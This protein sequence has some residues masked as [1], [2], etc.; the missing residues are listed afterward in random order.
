MTNKFAAAMRRATSVTRGLNVLGA[1]RIIQKAL[2]ASM[3]RGVSSRL[4]DKPESVRPPLGPKNSDVITARPASEAVVGKREKPRAAKIPATTARHSSVPKRLRRPLG[5]VLEILRTAAAQPIPIAQGPLV[6][7]GTKSKTS[8]VSMP[9]GASFTARTFTCSEGTRAFKLY[10][11]ASAPQKPKGLIV[12]LHGCTQDP[13]DFAR[14]TNMNSFAEL[15]GLLIA[16]PAQPR[17]SNASS[18]WNW[19]EG[20]HQL[21]DTGEPAILAG[22][23]RKLIKQF[24]IDQ[25]QV[26]VAGL[27]AGAAMAVI[28]AKTYPDIFRAVGVHSGLAYQSAGNVMSAL[29]VMRGRKGA[30]LFAKSQSPDNSPNLVRTIIFHGSSDRTVHPSNAQR[31]LEMAHQASAENSI[32]TTTGSSNG[33]HF[34]QTLILQKN[35]PVLVESWMIDGAGHAWS[36]GNVSGSYADAR[37]PVA[38]AEMVRFF[39][40]PN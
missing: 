22:L 3:L 4:R 28:L 26:F 36:G 30:S 27:S 16:Y 12:M 2:A 21:R 11:P 32:A 40:T 1:T 7:L 20:G 13:D 37:G 15:H 19:F 33:R 18:C 5:D 29:A 17:A 9:D 10:V 38:S 6:S 24:G 39:L 23:T 14:G 35:G 25:E 31:I 8:V 34:T